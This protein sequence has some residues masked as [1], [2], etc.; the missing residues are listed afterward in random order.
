MKESFIGFYRPTEEELADLWKNCIF[1][2]DANV[3]LDL[4]R[5]PKEARDDL[6]GILRKISDR[7]WVPYQAAL[8][9]QENRLIVIA[10]QLKKYQDVRQVIVD[11]KNKLVGNL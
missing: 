5:Y 10:D 8:E 3:L 2:L 9:Y 7:L 6:I 1:I 4:Y 11:I